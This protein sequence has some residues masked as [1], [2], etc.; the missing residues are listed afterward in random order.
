MTEDRDGLRTLSLFDEEAVPVLDGT[1]QWVPV[2]RRLGIRAFG[3]NAYRAAHA[4]D[5]VV[6]EHVES[7]GHEELYLVVRGRARF[8]L[9]E[10]VEAA[11]GELVFLPDPDLRR[12]AVALD[13]DTVVFAVGGW[14][15]RPYQPLPWE[16]VFLAQEQ[17]RRG[18]WAGAAETLQREAGEHEASPPVLYHLARCHAQTGEHDRALDELRRAVADRPD[19]LAAAAEEEALAPLRGLEGWPGG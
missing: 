18:D 12:R 8:D 14:A 13:D 4:G 16:P 1:L 6:E 15:G 2:R 19:L 5:L 11:A 10:V 3:T 9:G 7:Q 17:M